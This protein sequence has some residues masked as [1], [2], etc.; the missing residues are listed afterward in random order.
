MNEAPP[1]DIGPCISETVYEL[2][3]EL[4]S[5]GL[6]GRTPEEVAARFIEERL[7]DFVPAPRLQLR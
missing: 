1:F 5:L 6:Y 3:C 2:L 7:R 4:V